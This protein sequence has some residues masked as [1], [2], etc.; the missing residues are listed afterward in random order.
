[1]SVSLCRCCCCLPETMRMTVESTNTPPECAC[2]FAD[3]VFT[4]DPNYG[5]VY[6]GCWVLNTTFS[7]TVSGSATIVDQ[8]VTFTLCCL[9]NIGSSGCE[10]FQL[11]DGT[12]TMLPGA[13]P[14]TCDPLL[15]VWDC[16]PIGCY[17]CA[18]ITITS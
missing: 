3:A 7:C 17:T 9:G 1:M 18:K 11:S 8:P 6:G 4:F 16:F 10:S 13:T 15:L 14:C 2:T 12:T 5:S